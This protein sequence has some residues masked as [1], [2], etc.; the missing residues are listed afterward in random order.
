M[1]K[2][3]GSVKK[4]IIF[5]FYALLGGC[6]VM[7]DTITENIAGQEVYVCYNES[8][9][10][11]GKKTLLNIVDSN[12][13]RQNNIFKIYMLDSSGRKESTMWQNT[14]KDYLDEIKRDLFHKPFCTKSEYEHL[15]REKENERL[16]DLKRQKELQ[17]TKERE[18][19]DCKQAKIKAQARNDELKN[20]EGNIVVLDESITS[21]NE[22]R[23][24]N[25]SFCFKVVG[26]DNGGIVV[27]SRC[28]FSPIANIL[29]DAFVGC[30]EKNY[31]I[32]TSDDYAD[33]E[34]YKDWQYLHKYAGVYNW[35]GKRIRAFRKTNYKI[36]EIE[37]QT[38]LK[39]K[40]HQ[41]N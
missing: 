28:T 8:D 36:S 27:E 19:A 17:E 5:I 41:C 3:D 2:K 1:I 26:Y 21:N 16:A 37:Y 22:N 15:L 14:S 29:L 33:G 6:A 12:G 40:T 32:Y 38:Y 24:S 35:K 34:C 23:T 9:L 13:Y 7:E 31:F 10:T 30:E 11:I 4:S 18:I 20:K 39:D 25:W